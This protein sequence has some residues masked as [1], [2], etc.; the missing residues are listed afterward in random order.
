MLSLV[1][2]PEE[3]LREIGTYLNRRVLL[4]GVVSGCGKTVLSRRVDVEDLEF[5][6]TESFLHMTGP[7]KTW[8]DPIPPASGV[9]KVSSLETATLMTERFSL[10]SLNGTMVGTR[11]RAA[12]R[13]LEIKFWNQGNAE[14]P[15]IFGADQLE[16][17]DMSNPE[18]LAMND[19]FMLLVMNN[20]ALRMIDLRERSSSGVVYPYRID[21]FPGKYK[22]LADRAFKVKAQCMG[23][24]YSALWRVVFL[25]ELE[26]S[27]LAVY[28]AD[29]T[30]E[31]TKPQ[32]VPILSMKMSHK[33]N[34][35]FSPGSFV[36]GSHDI[37]FD[38]TPTD[39][40]IMIA[41]KCQSPHHQQI[42]IRVHKSLENTSSPFLESSLHRVS[43]IPFSINEPK[44]KLIAIQGSTKCIFLGQTTPPFA[45]D[46]VGLPIITHG[47]THHAD[48]TPAESE[49]FRRTNPALYTHH[50]TIF[51]QDH[52][53]K[54][55][56]ASSSRSSFTTARSS[57]PKR[58]HVC[59]LDH[60]ER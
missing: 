33:T 31:K 19:K 55:A 52:N 40:R 41:V 17:T 13:R 56:I 48:P 3:L 25:C 6:D 43:T 23:N 24:E 12:D 28:F 7:W 30:F 59:E 8:L 32:E 36:P 11:L 29:F 42:V 27:N 54:V 37:F 2:L 4:Y 50:H 46:F 51:T 49:P 60:E 38:S 39:V 15:I 20:K 21:L 18:P 16:F 45:I 58:Q 1:N 26:S 5:T 44:G 34:I 9:S 35:R 10:H 47:T 53:Y 22:P 14:T 57:A